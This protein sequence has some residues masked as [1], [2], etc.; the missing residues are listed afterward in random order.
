M[1]TDIIYIYI[2]VYIYEKSN[3]KLSGFA[4]ARASR[5]GPWL[6][7][8]TPGCAVLQRCQPGGVSSWI[9]GML[10]QVISMNRT[11]LNFQT[12]SWWFST[13]NLDLSP[14]GVKEH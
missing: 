11:P 7:G 6:R 14:V 1:Y 4:Q 5:S 10:G 12:W 3:E 9:K 2:Y 13:S 8:E